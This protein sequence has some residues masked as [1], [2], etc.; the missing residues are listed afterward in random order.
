M[1]IVINR[2]YGG[3][4]LSK[5]AV[6]RYVELKNLKVHYLDDEFGFTY[7]WLIPEGSDPDTQKKWSEMDNGEIQV[8]EERSSAEGFYPQYIE[9]DDPILVQ[10]VE[11]L[12]SKVNDQFSELKV[13]EIP[14]DVDWV[15]EDYDGVETI[16]ERSR[17]WK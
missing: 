16:R 17:S 14:D 4:G 15:V 6:T 8:S 5:E 12:G 2:C 3:F 11:E 1:K 7:Y 9:R 13:V 10:V